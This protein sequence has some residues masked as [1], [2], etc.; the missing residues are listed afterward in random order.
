LLWAII[1][2]LFVAVVGLWPT[3]YPYGADLKAASP[4]AEDG[5]HAVETTILWIKPGE[6]LVGIFT[7][8]LWLATVGLVRGA[9]DTA[10][11]QLRPYVYVDKAAVVLEGDRLN[12]VIDVKNSGQTPA[13]NFVAVSRI[14]AI[15]AGKKYIPRPFEDVKLSRGILGP[16]GTFNPFVS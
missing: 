4:L 16:A 10:K 15:G 3:H 9:E 8:M 14:D 12:A 7:G 2:S 5:G 1:F 13:Y 11:R 6:W